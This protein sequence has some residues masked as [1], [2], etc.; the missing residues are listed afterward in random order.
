VDWQHKEDIQREMR[1]D[2]KHPLRAA[3]FPEKDLD[4]TV[5][6]IVDLLKARKIS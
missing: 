4:Q 2:I 5:A 3:H 1:R 6:G